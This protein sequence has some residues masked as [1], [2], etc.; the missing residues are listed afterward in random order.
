MPNLYTSLLAR[1]RSRLSVVTLAPKNQLSPVNQKIESLPLEDWRAQV[2]ENHTAYL[3]EL[4]QLEPPSRSVGVIG[5]G[6]AGLSAAY[7]LRKRGYAVTI[8]EASNYPGGRTR[9]IHHVVRHHRMDGGAELIGSNHALWLNYAEIFRLGLSDVLDYKKSPIILG[10]ARLSASAGKR[11]L[12]QMD[13]AFGYI[14]ARAK[15]IVDP[16]SP[17]TDPQATT[18]DQQNVHRGKPCNSSCRPASVR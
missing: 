7:E 10:E 1:H 12:H 5:A 13:D 17:W 11:L 4:L 2:A 6:L 8:L 9:T 15:T 3:A 16:F 14:S 18:L